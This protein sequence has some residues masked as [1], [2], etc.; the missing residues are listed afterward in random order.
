[1]YKIGFIDNKL[2]WIT[3]TNLFLLVLSN[4]FKRY[5][6]MLSNFGGID[7]FF[8]KL[9]LF[10]IYFKQF[11]LSLILLYWNLSSGSV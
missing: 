4:A 11:S 5:T 1:M 7:D 6:Y 2:N 10:Q 3:Y 9:N 8:K